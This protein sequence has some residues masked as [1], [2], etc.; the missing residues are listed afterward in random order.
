MKQQP[1]ITKYVMDM[2]HDCHRLQEI[3]SKH[4]LPD[5]WRTILWCMVSGRWKRVYADRQCTSVYC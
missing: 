1:E 3:F 5:R 4:L 2:R